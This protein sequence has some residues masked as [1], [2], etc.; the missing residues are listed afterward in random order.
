M[1]RAIPSIIGSGTDWYV[2][3]NSGSSRVVM[4]KH[5]S[6]L[7]AERSLLGTADRIA[8]DNKWADY[9]TLGLAGVLPVA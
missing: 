3:D 2:C 9:A 4:S 8:L 7:D 1:S 6:Q 5:S